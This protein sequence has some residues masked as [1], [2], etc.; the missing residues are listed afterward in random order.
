MGVPF[1]EFRRQIPKTF[2]CISCILT[3]SKIKCNR[4]GEKF[5]GGFW[6]ER[7][8]FELGV[9]REE[10]GVEIGERFASP[11]PTPTKLILFL[12]RGRKSAK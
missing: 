6:R 10:G 5:F 3:D 11:F 2:L 8:D 4:R 9:R 1:Q 7:R 12:D